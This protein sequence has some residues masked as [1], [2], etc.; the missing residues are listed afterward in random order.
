MNIIVICSGCKRELEIKEVSTRMNGLNDITVEI[1][2]CNNIDCYDCSKCEELSNLKSENKK[3]SNKIK[4]AAKEL[5]PTPDIK[6]G[7]TIIPGIR[8]DSAEGTKADYT[9]L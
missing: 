4:N 6:I 2:P 8:K 7:D 3:L 1:S 9:R 5:Q